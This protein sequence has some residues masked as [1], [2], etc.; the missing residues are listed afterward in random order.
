MAHQSIGYQFNT[1]LSLLT[2]TG[3]GLHYVDFHTYSWDN[4]ERKDNHCL[5]QYCVDGEGVLEYGRV[6]FPVRPGDAFLIDI[7]GESRY[8][9][10]EDSSHWEVL[11]LE[12]SKEC[13]PYIWKIQSRSGPVVHLP[14]ESGIPGSLFSIYRNSLETPPATVFANSRIAYSCWMDL[15]A[16]ALAG[17]QGEQSK[18]DH[19]KAYIDQN[20]HQSSLSLDMLADMAGISRFYLC[21]EFKRRFGLPPGQYLKKLRISQA[22]RLLSVNADYTMQ[23]IAQMV[24]YSN[25]NYFGKVFKAATGITPDQYRK[26]TVR[27]DLVRLVYE[28]PQN[29]YTPEDGA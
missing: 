20:Y 21:K 28:T 26:R 12:F 11:Y 29:I 15:T 18:I 8:F 16:Y 13:L 19:V 25:N 2:L 4:R 10:P 24:G 14:P 27:Y 22:C 17:V 23:D 3:I 7:P 9:L 6:N 5:V 1:D